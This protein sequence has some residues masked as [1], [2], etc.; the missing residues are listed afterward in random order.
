MLKAPVLLWAFVDRM[1]LHN[2]DDY[3]HAFIDEI[4]TNV[5]PM[6]GPFEALCQQV[7]HGDGKQVQAVSLNATKC[8][9]F[10]PAL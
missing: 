1:S 5:C 8:S 9:R 3:E 2:I 4:G 10:L 6:L 7:V